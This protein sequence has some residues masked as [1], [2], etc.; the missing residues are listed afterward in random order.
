MAN[1]LATFKAQPSLTKQQYKLQIK[2]KSSFSFLINVKEL[3]NRQYTKIQLKSIIE[4]ILKYLII[5]VDLESGK[6]LYSS[7][8]P[9]GQTTKQPLTNFEHQKPWK[10]KQLW[11]L[12]R[13]PCCL[14]KKISVKFQFH[15]LTIMLYILARCC[16]EIFKTRLWYYSTRKVKS[17]TRQ[18]GAKMYGKKRNFWYDQVI[19]LKLICI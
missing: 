6:L 10:Y 17:Y 18:D 13:D 15:A 2:E 11:G 3:L 5:N 8:K 1:C 16:R 9:L 14:W 7:H 19:L 12:K 4:K